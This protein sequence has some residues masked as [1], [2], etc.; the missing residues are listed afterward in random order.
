MQDRHTIQDELVEESWHRLRGSSYR[1]PDW[2]V[3][4]SFVQYQ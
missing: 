2:L 1:S 3:C 4:L